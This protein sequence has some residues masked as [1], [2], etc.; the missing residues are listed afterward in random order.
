MGWCRTSVPIL[1]LRKELWLLVRDESL[2]RRTVQRVP[3]HHLCMHAIY[4][5]SVSHSFPLLRN[6]RKSSNNAKRPPRRD[7]AAYLATAA[8]EIPA[9]RPA[10]NAQV[11]ANIPAPRT[12]PMP[13]SRAE[14]PDVPTASA[15]FEFP[16]PVASYP[17]HTPH[18]AMTIPSAP[19]PSVEH[20]RPC[21]DHQTHLSPK[22]E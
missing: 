5:H 8:V 18:R 22:Y 13:T 21:R 19:R 6:T 14:A 9:M 10:C 15:V 12:T 3:C 11:I 20:R 17:L 1:L 7:T 2:A 4:K 16:P